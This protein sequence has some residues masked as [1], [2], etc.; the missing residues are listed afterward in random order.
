MASAEASGTV[1]NRQTQKIM[2]DFQTLLAAQL[3]FLRDLA[4]NVVDGFNTLTGVMIGP[5][6]TPY[7]NGH[8]PFLIQFPP[9]YPFK[10]PE[11][12]FNPAV[13]HPNVH[14]KTGTACHDQLMT[15][16]SPKVKLIQLLTEMHSLLAKPNYD[17]PVQ[18]DIAVDTSPE[19][20]RQWTEKYAQP[21]KN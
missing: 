20:C 2:A 19:N 21:K 4:L 3:P 11:F 5:E 13:L 14:S 7:A 6:G 12:I 8:F 1:P 18:G 15:T 9:E 17:A 16:W 10:P